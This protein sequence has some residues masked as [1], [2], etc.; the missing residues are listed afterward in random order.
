MA[1][2]SELRSIEDH[3][4]EPVY[5]AGVYIVIHSDRQFSDC[6]AKTGSWLFMKCYATFKQNV[7]FFFFY[8]K[9]TYKRLQ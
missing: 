8:N 1:P 3:R 2:A 9:E 4:I 5:T 7:L 6:L